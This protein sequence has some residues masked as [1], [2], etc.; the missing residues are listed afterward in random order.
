[1]PSEVRLDGLLAISHSFGR[2]GELLGVDRHIREEPSASYEQFRRL[3][4]EAILR[5]INEFIELH[6]QLTE[7]V[8][9]GVVFHD[10]SLLYKSETN[11]LRVIDL[12]MYHFG[13]F[14]NTI[15]RMFGSTRF[16]GPEELEL[17]DDR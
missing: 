4:V 17:G 10:G 7:S 15:W 13:P 1:M 8:W 5:V 2:I 11:C 12:D 16:I 9:I 14:R 3:Q 6:A